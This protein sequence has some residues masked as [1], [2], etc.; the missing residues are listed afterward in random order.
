MLT[1]LQNANAS[2]TDRHRLG[3]AIAHIEAAISHI[4]NEAQHHV[5]LRRTDP[6]REVEELRLI[7]C[8]LADIVEALRSGSSARP[9][10]VPVSE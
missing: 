8:A 6:S 2:A 4:N 7:V 9:P 1:L 10:R 3:V 5:P